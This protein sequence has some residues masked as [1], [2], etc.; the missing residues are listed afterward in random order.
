MIWNQ[1]SPRQPTVWH[2]LSSAVVGRQLFFRPATS[3]YTCDRSVRRAFVDHHD[4]HSDLDDNERPGTRAEWLLATRRCGLLQY[5][6]IY[7]HLPLYLAQNLPHGGLGAPLIS[8]PGAPC[9][10][11]S[12][13]IWHTILGH[14]EFSGSTDPRSVP[15]PGLLTWKI[16]SSPIR[17]CFHC[18]KHMNPL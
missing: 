15:Y 9:A 4:F 13:S 10:C 11:V 6:P 12:V 3:V 5:K 8:P 17:T 18:N 16:T 14:R 1:N 7:R 2:L